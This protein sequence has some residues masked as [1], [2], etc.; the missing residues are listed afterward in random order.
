MLGAPEIDDQPNATFVSDGGRVVLACQPCCRAIGIGCQ[1][2]ALV[3][4]LTVDAVGLSVV[5]VVTERVVRADI[6]DQDYRGE[7]GIELFLERNSIGLENGFADNDVLFLHHRFPDNL[8]PPKPSDA[9]RQGDSESKRDHA[10]R[11]TQ[12]PDA[13]SR[14]IGIMIRGGSRRCGD[15]GRGSSGGGAQTITNTRRG[16]PRDW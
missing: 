13:S 11:V 9:D 1:L 6:L 8:L 5:V 3:A 7:P 2:G 4:L 15:G 10:A 12:E 14:K 16:N